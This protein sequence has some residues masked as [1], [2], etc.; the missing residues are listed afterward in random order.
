M[1]EA[2]VREQ[3][4]QRALGSVDPSVAVAFHS[5]FGGEGFDVGDAT[6]QLTQADE[7]AAKLGVSHVLDDVGTDDEVEGPTQAQIRDLAQSA[8]QNVASAAKSA[9]DVLA[10]LDA[11]VADLS[12]YPTQL[13]PPRSLA[14][15]D[16]EH[17]SDRSLQERLRR[18]HRQVDFPAQRLPRGDSRRGV[19][20]PSPIVVAIVALHVV[21]TRPVEGGKLAFAAPR[22]YCRSVDIRSR[23]SDPEVEELAR[24]IYAMFPKCMRCG[25]PID[26]YED[27]DIRILSH[28][29]VHRGECGRLED[30]A[31]A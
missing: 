22:S 18:R 24:S 13:G 5:V 31:R 9:N 20:I 6:G 15:T 11:L 28:R 26:R 30:Q 25:L 19:T 12:S 2:S 4:T 29:V 8:A 3:P 10:R 23:P 1:R 16:V 17:G 14:A 21:E 27:A 7:A